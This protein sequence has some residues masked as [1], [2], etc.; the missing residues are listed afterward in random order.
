MATAGVG[1]SQRVTLSLRFA[2][3]SVSHG[4]REAST[5]KDTK[6]H[7]GKNRVPL[8]VVRAPGSPRIFTRKSSR[9]TRLARRLS[10]GGTGIRVWVWVWVWGLGPEAGL[11]LFEEQG[12]FL[13]QLEKTLGILL[14]RNLFTKFSPS[15]LFFAKHEHTLQRLQEDASGTGSRFYYQMLD[16]GKGV[17]QNCIE[18]GIPF[19][20]PPARFYLRI[21][22][23]AYLLP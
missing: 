15:F 18:N 6:D 23:V 9:E 11:F 22:L 13:H 17:L 12:D 16:F 3:W 4:L 5:T 10:G 21:T 1:P 2:M 20:E 14:Y 7:K 8:V 19:F